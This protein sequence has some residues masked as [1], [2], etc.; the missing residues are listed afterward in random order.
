ML[1]TFVSTPIFKKW[2]RQYHPV[3]IYK[4][5]IKGNGKSK[6]ESHNSRK[7][8]KWFQSQRIHFKKW[9]SSRKKQIH[10]SKWKKC[11]WTWLFFKRKWMNNPKRNSTT[12][13][14]PKIYQRWYPQKT[15]CFSPLWKGNQASCSTQYPKVEQYPNHLSWIFNL[16]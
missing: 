4:K 9:S 16:N 12:W 14:Q 7:K 10:S 5:M 13:N 6:A 8:L 2:N 1:K 15:A 11:D 3:R